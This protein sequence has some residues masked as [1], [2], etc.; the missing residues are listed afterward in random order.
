[1]KKI[2]D[3][4]V[5]KKAKTDYKKGIPLKDIS[6]KY[7]IPYSTVQ[8]WHKKYWQDIKGND[9]RKV[10]APKN[11]S[12]TGK[13]PYANPILESMTEEEREIFYS[14]GKTPEEQ[15]QEE[16]NL[17]TIR[18]CRILKTLE[19]YRNK[20]AYISREAKIVEKS[21][22]VHEDGEK[23]RAERYI[24]NSIN[25]IIRLEAELTK[26]QGKKTANIEKLAK[27]KLDEK[28]S[29]DEEDLMSVWIDINKKE[30]LYE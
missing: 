21:S 3:D 4:E 15:L 17:L 20:D 27:L 14:K 9:K 24:D 19:E 8:T 30:C 5:K 13:G 22:Y 16:I 11:N 29:K 18:E 23:N 6:E 7:S 26:V 10:T 12:K 2:Y 1:M 28:K 25:M